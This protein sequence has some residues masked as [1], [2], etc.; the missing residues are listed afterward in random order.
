MPKSIQHMF[1]TEKTKRAQY[2]KIWDVSSEYT[3][4]EM[5]L[6]DTLRETLFNSPEDMV[7]G[8]N[9]GSEGLSNLISVVQRTAFQPNKPFFETAPKKGSELAAL[10]PAK[11]VAI[12]A[13]T[14]LNGSLALYK[15]G[16]S[17][18]LYYILGRFL[19][20]GTVAWKLPTPGTDEMIEV[21]ELNDIV[22]KRGYNGKLAHLII[23]DKTTLNLLPEE[24][25]QQVA[26][27]YKDA[28]E[29]EVS[30]YTMLEANEYGKYEV[31]QA[32]DE[33][34]LD[35]AHNFTPGIDSPY[36]VSSL[37][38]PRGRNYG[39]G[40]VYRYLK[41]L[42]A[43]NV[44]RDA[45]TDVAAVGSLLNWG[46]T[47]NAAVNPDEFEQRSQGQAFSLREGDVFPIVPKIGQQYQ[48][49]ANSYA[50]VA[51]TLQR[52]FMVFSAVQRNAERVTAE[53]IKTVIRAL[54][55]SHSGVYAQVGSQIQRPLAHAALRMVDNPELKPW[56]SQMDIQLVSVHESM[57]RAAQNSNLLTSLNQISVLNSIPPEI[58]AGLKKQAI[59]A[60]IFA[61]NNAK[62]DDYVMTEEEVAQAQAQQSQQTQPAV[63]QQQ[64]FSSNDQLLAALNKPLV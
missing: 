7:E 46:V 55:E 61:N 45:N 18:A 49:T 9:I 56:V 60:A 27:K 8:D 16:L 3:I 26:D 32:V 52:A 1:E 63:Q 6:P 15:H 2:E 31:R 41:W 29:R 17:E 40:A 35:V 47:P 13:E 5:Y 57:G 19:C 12:C 54:E 4:R 14:A 38:T 21:Y 37:F 48:L 62:V 59:I 39:V 36:Q 20:V 34:E 51:Q 25:R 11:R 10:P 50:E 28:K 30:L 64:N 42:H 22:V 53:E 33:H 23:Q 24:I 58:S 44:Y 43:A